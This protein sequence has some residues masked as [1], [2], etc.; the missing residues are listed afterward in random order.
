MKRKARGKRLEVRDPRSEMRDE[1]SEIGE[2]QVPHLTSHISHLTSLTSAAKRQAGR[3]NVPIAVA[4]LVLSFMLWLVVYANNLPP[5]VPR[6]I[7]VKLE[8][9]NLNESKFVIVNIP[10]TLTVEAQGTEDALE[11]IQEQDRVALID[12]ATAQPGKRLYPARVYPDPLRKILTGGTPTAV[13]EIE[14]LERKMTAVVVDTRGK[15]RPEFADYRLGNTL[16]QPSQVR[17]AGPKS[18]VDRL[19][20]VRAVLDLSEVDPNRSEPYQVSLEALDAKEGPLPGIT[21]DPLF[22]SITPALNPAPEEKQVLVVPQFKGTPA[23][24]FVPA[25]Y[26][27]DP[28]Q[29]PLRGESLPLAKITKVLTEEINV[30]GLRKDTEFRVK[31]IVPRGMKTVRQRTVT[32]RYLVRAAPADASRTPKAPKGGAAGTP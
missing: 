2:G 31:L 17:V 14:A 24:G 9:Q 25:G 19:A 32:V 29:V 7:L 15:L 26:E 12:L 20:Q 21:T 1:R 28:T 23:A 11:R 16:V 27:L 22:V 6:P 3:A 8:P 10:P 30:E 4:S 5:T 13:V 18:Q